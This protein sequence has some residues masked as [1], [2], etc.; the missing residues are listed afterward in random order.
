MNLRWKIPA[1]L[2]IAVLGG[3]LAWLYRS[4]AYFPAKQVTASLPATSINPADSIPRAPML[5]P[6]ARSISLPVPNQGTNYVPPFASIAAALQ[7][8]N[9]QERFAALARILEEWSAHAPADALAWARQQSSDLRHTAI[10]DALIGMA[11]QPQI[12]VRLGSML[13]RQEPDHADDYALALV[14]GLNDQRQFPL[15]IQFAESIPSN[16]RP[17]WL[18]SIFRSWGTSEPEGALQA[19]DTMDPSSRDQIFHALIDGW[20]VS[21]PAQLAAYAVSMPAGQERSYALAT[22]IDRWSLQDPTGMADWLAQIGPSPE[23]DPAIAAMLTRSDGVNRP[24]SV[25]MS[26]AESIT[27]PSLRF[28]TA[29]HVMAEWKQSDSVGARAYVQSA[30]WLTPAQRISLLQIIDAPPPSL[31]GPADD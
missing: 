10:I 23:L 22:A 6:V 30:A 26:W 3:E 19:L 16:A 15:A 24:P 1:L 25:A 14:Q 8:S 9:Q 20:S 31:A 2:A 29:G 13:I 27:D 4:P 18:A 12:A 21:Q 11:A 28:S 7:I 17:D 5:N